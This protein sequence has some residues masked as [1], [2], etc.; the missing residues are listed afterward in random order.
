MKV[1]KNPAKVEDKDL[2][3]A[4]EVALRFFRERGL[5]VKEVRM[6]IS[7]FAPTRQKSMI[8]EISPSSQHIVELV[9]LKQSLQKEVGKRVGITLV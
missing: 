6:S 3:E 1:I 9:Q 2:A 4:Y 8:I 5:K 7:P